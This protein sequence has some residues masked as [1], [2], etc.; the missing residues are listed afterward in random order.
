MSE[1]LFVSGAAISNYSYT[2]NGAAVTIAPADILFFISG[3]GGGFEIDYT[4]L[5][6]DTN[7]GPCVPA[8]PCSFDAFGSQFFSGAPPEI[9]I[10]PGGS[11]TSVDFDGFGTNTP[12]SFS[13]TTSVATPEPATLSLLALGALGLLAKRRKK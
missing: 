5:G 10:V 11:L 2:L 13:V 1:A 8:S 7:G 9:T 4:S 12:N 6:S 3:Q